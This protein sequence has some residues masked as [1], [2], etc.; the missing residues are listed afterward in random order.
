MKG[1]FEWPGKLQKLSKCRWA[2]KSTCT[3]AQRASK[4]LRD[5]LPGSRGELAFEPRQARLQHGVMPALPSVSAIGRPASP[6]LQ[7][8]ITR[9]LAGSSA[10]P[11]SP[12]VQRMERFCASPSIFAL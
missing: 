1:R 12:Y 5:D 11:V 10:G 6:P 4:T 8:L 7:T 9:N 2:W 3:P